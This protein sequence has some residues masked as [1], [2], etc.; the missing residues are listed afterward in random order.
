MNII[1]ETYADGKPFWLLK[2]YMTVY[3]IDTAQ[4]LANT[5]AIGPRRAIHVNLARVGISHRHA[6][7]EWWGKNLSASTAC[8]QLLLLCCA[9]MCSDV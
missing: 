6:L 3:M 9:E 5:I 7:C 8:L 2:A 4:I 1:K